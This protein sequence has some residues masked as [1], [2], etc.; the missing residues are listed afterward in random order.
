MP[1]TVPLPIL[2]P[3]AGGLLMPLLKKRGMIREVVTLLAAAANLFIAAS[4]FKSGPATYNLGWQFFGIEFSLRLY[5]FS[6]FI[7]LAIA[8]FGFLTALYC[9]VFMRG[10]KYLSQFYACLLVT[11]ALAGGAVLADNLVLLLFFWE[12]LL[13][14]LLVMIAIGRQG[15]FKTAIKAFIIVGIADLCLMAG[16]AFLGRLAGTLAISKI[17]LTLSSKPAIIAFLLLMSGAI[18]KAGSM[19]FHSWIPDAAE[20]APLAF[21]AFM[22]AALEKLLGIY[23]LA[24][25]SLDIFKLS[26]NSALSTLL[27]IIGSFTI[28]AAVMLALVQKNYKKLL[29]YHAI[30]QVGY[31]ILGIGTCLPVGIIGGLFHMINNALYK[32]CLFFTAGAVERQAGTADLENL[33]GLGAKMP[34]TF[35]C[36]LI[37]AAAISGVPPLN[38]FF[39]KELIYDAALARGHVFYLAA[40]LGSFFTAASFLKLGHAA[41]LGKLNK[42]NIQTKEAPL[43]MLTPMIIIA[44]LC[45]IFGIYNQAVLKTFIRPVLSEGTLPGHVS[46]VNT[47]LVIITLLVL[48]AA[49]VNHILGVK[50]SGSSLHATDHIRYAPL[51]SGIYERAQ[52]KYFDPYEIGLKVMRPFLKVLWLLDRGIDWIYDSFITTLTF[53]LSFAISRLHA[54]SFALYIA[55]SLLG[56]SVVVIWMVR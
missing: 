6:A 29:A 13:L 49:L 20:D 30:S 8:L 14:T 11:L 12:G 15:A 41:Y 1:I 34:V 42:E 3:L 38:G 47:T 46:S 36:F 22:P 2:V 54:G 43:A 27:M 31:M 19:P 51:L 21:M 37:S 7:L 25:I 23:F 40:L 4:L 55:W 5:H 50:I 48:A 44:A 17:S 10:K 45:A 33:G 24:R 39:S 53:A 26:G 9:A 35:F 52:K 56:A 16:I 28:L 32:S 18:A